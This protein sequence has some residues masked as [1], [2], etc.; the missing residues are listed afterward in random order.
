[1]ARTT[2]LRVSRL[3][4]AGGDDL[5]PVPLVHVDAVVVVEEV[6][7]ADGPHVGAQALA[8]A[9]AELV[10]GDALPLGRRLHDLRVEGMAVVVVRD[11]EPDGRPRA[12]AVEHVVDARR[13]VDDERHLDHREV[14]LTAQVLLDV[15]LDRVDG[16]LRLLG[17]EGRVVVGRQHL[18]QFVVVADAGSGQVGFL[19]RGQMDRRHRNA[20]SARAWGISFAA[21]LQAEAI[22]RSA[23]AMRQGP[24]RPSRG[25]GRH[26]PAHMM[27]R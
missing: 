14:Q 24:I 18:G 4:S 23:D 12:V 10:Q 27:V 17:G 3:R 15:A 25:A 7:L 19:R 8:E 26:V 2:S 9:H 11:V 20:S 22:V 21:A 1:M 5:L 13:D 6:V 16:L